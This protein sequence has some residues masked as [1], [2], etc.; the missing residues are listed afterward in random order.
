MSG[1]KF[2]VYEALC[3]LTFT[4][5]TALTDPAAAQDRVNAQGSEN[6]G[7]L[8]RIIPQLVDK[9]P[10]KLE[11]IFDTLGLKPSIEFFNCLCPPR[12]WYAPSKAGPCE[13]R[14]IAYATVV[15]TNI[16]KEAF[17]TCL[18]KPDGKDVVQR[19][20]Q[21]V[22]KPPSD[23]C[24]GLGPSANLDPA[25]PLSLGQSN[26]DKLPSASE[27]PQHPRL[28]ELELL[29]KTQNIQIPQQILI[30]G[31]NESKLAW[32]GL[33]KTTSELRARGYPVLPPQNLIGIDLGV[34]HLAYGRI[35]ETKN[36]CEAA[37]SL[38]LFLQS[39]EDD[40]S[41]TGLIGELA[42]V[43]IIPNAPASLD[44]GIRA[45]LATMGKIIP[46]AIPILGQAAIAEDVLGYYDVL[47]KYMEGTVSGQKGR[48]SVAVFD[49]AMREEWDRSRV[50]E[51]RR[52]RLS[53]N[54]EVLSEIEG[55]PDAMDAEYA[56]LT[57]AHTTRMKQIDGERDAKIQTINE[58]LDKEL[59]RIAG[60]KADKYFE[61]ERTR[62]VLE[63]PKSAPP[64]ARMPFFSAPTVGQVQ[65]D[66]VNDALNEYGRLSNAAKLDASNARELAEIAA[67]PQRLFEQGK[68]EVQSRALGKRY[69]DLLREA[70]ERS[71]RL[72]AEDEALRR[73]VTPIVDGD[74]EKL[75]NDWA[76]EVGCLR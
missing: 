40:R 20:L 22:P 15:Y 28:S 64:G 39:R 14:T 2:L 21:L 19:L 5:S 56:Q 49:Q 72:S 16:V 9:S 62:W 13:G 31:Y 43:K 46:K 32:E 76:K 18:A 37:V 61:N 53:K 66:W 44:L 58:N 29:M 67:K 12:Y 54:D 50:E 34:L 33:L 57:K 69:N 27:F 25:T 63:H 45:A 52:A 60:L 6:Q 71:A 73:F 55:F 23:D 68:Y 42:L 8:S 1:L 47:M 36:S 24:A 75:R 35:K 38:R 70:L 48:W 7:A 51:E 65:A 17:A 74:C 59:A 30:D 10:K 11:A 4:A 26:V 3:V 41:V